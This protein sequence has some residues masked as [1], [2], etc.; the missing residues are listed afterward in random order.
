VFCNIKL[1]Q[2]DVKD[3]KTLTHEEAKKRMEKWLKMGFLN[4]LFLMGKA[5]F[6][7]WRVCL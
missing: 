1:A 7:F 4:P 5:D 2:T 6:L 3:G